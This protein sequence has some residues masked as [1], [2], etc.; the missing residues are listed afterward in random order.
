[1]KPIHLWRVG[2]VLLATLGSP[3]RTQALGS[4]NI[5]TYH[6][7]AARTGLN[8]DETLLSPLTVSPGSFGRL[9]SDSVDGQVYGEPLYVSGLTLAAGPYNGQTRDAIL[10]VT[11]HDS[12]YAFDAESAGVT[13]WTKS[14]LSA[15]VTTV[16]SP[17]PGYFDC[18]DITPEV[19][20]TGTPVLDTGSL[21]LYFVVDTTTASRPTASALVTHCL[22]ALDITTGLDAMTP[23]TISAA[24]PGAG[25]GGSVVSFDPV[26]QISQFE[27]SGLFLLGNNV[28]TSWTSHCDVIAP[29]LPHHGW[30]MAFNKSTLSPA[31]LFCTTPNG[32]S[33]SI[34]NSGAAPALDTANGAIY[35]ST[36][37]GTFDGSV[38]QDW[39]DSVLR[40]DGNS[41]GP[42]V[43]DYFTPYNQATLQTQDLDLGSGTVLLLPDAVGSAGVPHLSVTAGKLG[44]VFLMNRDNLGGYHPAVGPT[45]GASPTPGMDVVVESFAPATVASPYE[46]P[47]F[48]Y[49]GNGSHSGFIYV[50]F[51]GE[52]LRSFAVSNAAINPTPSSHSSEIYANR[53]GGSSVSSNGTTDGILW[54]LQAGTGAADETLRAYDASNLGA[55]LYNSAARVSDSPGIGVKFTVPL[56][57]NGRVY[58]GAQNQVVV[59]GLLPP[60]ATPTATLSPTITLT[61]TITP[62]PTVT[63]TPVEALSRQA[64]IAQPNWV[65]GSNPKVLFKTASTGDSLKVSVYTLA[66]ELVRKLEGPTASGQCEWDT[67]GIASGLYL[68]VVEH[69]GAA[70]PWKQ[71]TLK[72]LILR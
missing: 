23:V 25:D 19:G 48:S 34:W 18:S 71:E 72:V 70:G 45:P 57:A 12:V 50:D 53:G 27:R 15:G 58:V 7:D 66:G 37:D 13:L 32:V 29:A 33:G 46:Y 65:G 35:C 3:L 42:T 24:L 61:S 49:Y 69:G 16:M 6:N 8:P 9:F 21:L 63:L 38:S 5:W 28:Y 51:Q 43:V 4:L 2:F 41:A 47:I 17:D 14:F 40:L 44:I 59:Y 68:A 56:V 52:P 11:Q 62:T 39:G 54:A 67:R 55:E 1:M 64:V 30:M 10:V 26:T 36:A 31:G 20:I 60:T 22:H